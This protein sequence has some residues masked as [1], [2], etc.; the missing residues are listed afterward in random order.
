MKEGKR[1]DKREEFIKEINTG[2]NEVVSHKKNSNARLQ[3]RPGPVGRGEHSTTHTESKRW[4]LK[5]A[6]SK[7]PTRA[8]GPTDRTD[9]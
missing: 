2:Q 5:C 3:Y 7:F 9:R 8:E 4:A 6:F 1:G